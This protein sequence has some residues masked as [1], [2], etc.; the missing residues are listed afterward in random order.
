MISSIPHDFADDVRVDERAHRSILVRKRKCSGSAGGGAGRGLELGILSQ[1]QG[2]QPLEGLRNGFTALRI[3]G[4]GRLDN[5]ERLAAQ[6]EGERLAGVS[7]F[8][9]E[10]EASGFELGKLERFHSKNPSGQI[11]WSN[12]LFPCGNAHRAATRRWFWLR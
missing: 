12:E 3:G 6:S 2:A 8:L 11:M 5:R 9:E 4:T 1:E 7:D 10:T